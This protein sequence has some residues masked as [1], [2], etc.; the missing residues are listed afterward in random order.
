MI[1]AIGMALFFPGVVVARLFWPTPIEV[2]TG[3]NE[4][5]KF[6]PYGFLGGL[7]CVIAGSICML[8]SIGLLVVR[9]MP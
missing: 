3:V 7:L 9:H 1:F 5:H 2:F 8:F 6:K 4:G